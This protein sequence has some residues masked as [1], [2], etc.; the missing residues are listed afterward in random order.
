MDHGSGAI[1]VTASATE[2]YRVEFLRLVAAT[3]NRQIDFTETEG[4]FSI[5]DRGTAITGFWPAISY[6]CERY[7]DPELLPG[8]CV[9][10]ALIRSLTEQL[11]TARTPT[12]AFARVRDRASFLLGSTPSLI[13]LAYLAVTAGNPNWS[14][15]HG[16]FALYMAR[17]PKHEALGAED[18][19]DAT[20][21]FEI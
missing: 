6:L 9:Q 7:P 4:A 3:R 19:E 2:S 15:L 14:S 1:R 8:D 11:L 12:D 17:R 13:D 21:A 20:E 10:R 16:A 5:Q 18:E